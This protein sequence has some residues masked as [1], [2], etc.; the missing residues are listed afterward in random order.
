MADNAEAADEISDI[1]IKWI[2]RQVENTF[3]NVKIEKFQKFMTSEES[4][5]IIYQFLDTSDVRTLLFNES[6]GSV[7]VSISAPARLKGVYLYFLKLQPGAVSKQD[8]LNEIT[9]GDMSGEP[10]VHMAKTM[11]EVYLPLLSNPSNQEAWSE[12]VTKDVMERMQ[13][14][15]AALQ[16]TRGQCKGE[17]Y[18]PLPPEKDISSESK[19]GNPKDRVHVLEGCL[20]T[21]TKQIKNVLKQ[22]PEM[23]LNQDQ[24][25]PGPL[26]ELEFWGAKASNLNSIFNQLQGE[27]IRKVLRFLDQSKSTYNLPFAKL[28]KEVFHAR[29]EAND[30]YKFLRPLEDWFSRLETETFRQL[31]DIFRPM[32]HL[33]L[34][35][36]KGSS[37]YNTPARLVVLVREVCNSLIR[38]SCN[39]TGGKKIFE[40]ID[41]EETPKVVEMLRLTL[42]VCGTFKST[43]FDYKAKANAED[44]NNQWRVQNN[45]LFVRLD[46]FLDRCHDLLELTQTIVQFSMLAKIEIGGT[47]G[48]T[49]TTSVHQ[50]HADFVAAVETIQSVGYDVM[51]L[52]A[53]EFDDDFYEFRA[54]IKELERRLGSVVTQGFDDCSSVTGHFKLLDSFEGLLERPLVQDELEK[55]HSV[56]IEAYSR[57]L[58][59]VQQM[60]M[61]SRDDPPITSNLP[62]T[63]GAL[64]WCHGLKERVQQPM[65]KLKSLNRAVMER[66]EAKD[67]VKAY[68]QLVASLEEFKHAKIE[69]WG[70]SIESSSQ[71]QLKLPLLRREAETHTLHV[72]FDPALVR[73][74][75]EVKYFL[76]LG[77]E[78]PDPALEIHKKSEVFRRQ[79]GNLD[80]IVNMYNGIQTSLLPVERPLVKSH[81]DKIDQVLAKGLRSLN[82]KSHGIDLFITESMADVREAS[83][84]LATMKTNLHRVVE[85]MEGWSS[86]RLIERASKPVN[87]EDFN[88]QS[89]PLRLT[90]YAVI[91]EGGNEVHKLLKDTNKR[92]RVSNGL[93]DWKAYIDFVNNIIVG[94]LAKVVTVSLEYLNEQIDP[95]MI[96]KEDK[97]PLLEIEL[98]LIGGDV[99]YLPEVS[100]QGDGGGI[101]DVLYGWIETFFRVASIFKRL[102][103]GEGTYVKEMREHPQIQSL[104]AD[105]TGNLGVMNERCEEYR[106][107]FADYE[108][109][110]T[111]DLSAIFAEFLETAFLCEEGAEDDDEERAD[112]EA[113]KEEAAEDDGKAKEDPKLDLAK[114][115]ERIKHFLAVQGEIG[116]IKASC[117]LCFLRVNS[118]PIKQ[119]LS[120]W[121]TKWVYMYTQY[122][123]DHV[124]LKLTTLNAFMVTVNAGLD[125]EVAP[126]DKQALMKCM[127]HIRDVRRI[128]D[129]TP[130]EFEPLRQAVALLK[131]HGVSMEEAMIG[132]ENVVESLESAPMRWD[133]TVNH[134]FKKKEVIQPLQNQMVETIKR[135]ISNFEKKVGEFVANFKVKA[136]FKS[137]NDDIDPP[138]MLDKTYAV[139]DEQHRLL[140]LIESEASDFGELEEL[141]ELSTSKYHALKDAHIEIHQL[142][143]VWDSRALVSALF[144]D[145]QQALWAD[146]DTDELVDETRLLQG[147]VKALPR[148]V[149]GWQVYQ[150]LEANVKNMGVVLPLVHELHSPAMRDRHWRNVM[151]IARRHFEMGPQFCLEDVLG[152]GLHQHVDNVLEVVEVAN[153]ELKIESKLH[154]IE[155]SWTGLPLEFMQYKDT[156]IQIISSPDVIV[157]MLE[158]HQLQLQTMAGMGKFVDY[159]RDRVLLWQ[160]RLGTVETTLK[161]WLSVQKQWSSL[162]SIFLCSADIMAQLPDDSKR[163]EGIDTELKELMRESC[164]GSL[165]L[166]ACTR[167][168]RDAQLSNMH[169]E[170]QIC[171]KALNEYL[172][173]KK[174]IFPRF[175]FVSNVALLDILSNGNN[176]PKVMPHIG[177]CFDGVKYLELQEPEEEEHKDGED[178]HEGQNKPK[179]IANVATKMISKDGEV[180]PLLSLFTMLGAVEHWLTELVGFM[181]DTLRE[182]LEHS[183]DTAANWEVDKPREQWLF[184]YPAQIVLVA[185]QIFWTEE[186]EGALEE[187]E[188]GQEDAVKS[189]LDLCNGRLGSLILLVL[190][191]LSKNDRAKIITLITID[192]HS[193][194]LVQSLIDKKTETGQDFIWQSQ[195]RFY[196]ADASRD[197]NIHICD[198]KSSYAY[199][200]VGNCG[201]LVITPLTDRCYV[202]L[203]T[204]LRLMLGGAP[205]GPAGT[206]KTETTKD[207]ARGL[208]LQCYVF[209]C[210]DQMNY[211]TMGDIFKGLSQ[212]GAWGC[213]D[214]FNRIII[215]VLSV[216]A[217]QVKTVLDAIVKFAVPGNREEKYQKLPAGTPPTKV[218]SYDFFGDSISLVP[219]TGFFIT[220]NPGYAG[221][222]ELPENLKA[223]FRS[224]AMI[225]PDLKP[226]CE[227]MLMAEGFVKARSLAVKFV[228]LY[229]L[230][231]E[232]LS[233]QA[234]YDWGLRAVKSV[235][236][237]AG[238]L[239]RSEPQI[240]EE[241]ILMRAL[242]DFNTPKI[243]ACDTP[244]FLQLVNDL[245]P[246]LA[247][248]PKVNETLK[249]ICIEVCNEQGLQPEEIFITKCVQYQELLDVRHSVMLLGPAGSAKSTIWK[250]LAACHNN[251]SS[252]PVTVY[253]PVNPKS[254]TSDELYG[255]MTLSKDWIDGCLS[256][257]M[258]NMSKEWA[259]YTAAQT[260]KWVILDGDIDAVWIES[261]NTV[262]DDNKVLT[263]VSNERIPLTAAMRMIF[264]IASLKNATPATVSRAGI[265]YLNE[266]DVGWQ[267]YVESWIHSCW[268]NEKQR[269]NF[270]LLFEK[271]MQK[272]LKLVRKN[273]LNHVIPITD[274][275][276][277]MTVCHLLEG[278]LEGHTD[279]SVEKTEAFFIFAAVWAL[280]GALASDKNENSRKQ[281]NELWRAEF[282]SVKYPDAGTVWDY[283]YSVERGEILPWTDQVPEYVPLGETQFANIVVP[284]VDSV[285]LSFLTKLLV[286]RQNPVMFVGVAGSGKTTLAKDFL[287]NLD[288]DTISTTIN[289]NY[290]T[291][292]RTLQQQLEQRI[293]KRSG[294]IYGPP[295]N[296][297]M[298]VLIDDLN[299]PFVEEY[300]TQTPIALL[301]QHVDYGGWYD[302]SDLGLRREVQDL[303]YIGCMNQK[304]GSFT[305]DPRLQRHFATF[306]C[307]MPG[308]E[309]LKTIYGTILHQHLATFNNG[310]Q[311][312]A[313]VVVNSTIELHHGVCE[314][315][316]PSAVKFHY[317]FNMRE[318]GAVFQGVCQSKSEY[319]SKPAKF[320]RLWLHEC[321]RVFSDRLISDNEIGRFSDMLVDLSKKHFDEDPN[322]LHKSPLIF[323]SFATPTIDETPAYLPVADSGQL[324]ECLQVKLKEYND[325]NPIM[326]L[327]L[328]AQAME[329]VTRITRILENPR[330]NALLVGVG[331]SG[332]QSLCKLGSFICGFQLM[333]ISVTAAYG[334]PDLKEDL[335]ELYRKAGLKPALPLVFMLTDAQIVNER[336]LVY[337]NDL[338]SS[339][340]IP[341][342]FAKDEID[343]ILGSLRNEAKAAGIPDSHDPMHEFFIDR[344]RSNLHVVLCMSPV[345]DLFRVRARKFPGLINCTSIDWFHAWPRDALVSVSQR[346]LEDVDLGEDEVKENISHHMAEVH[347]SVGKTSQNY[348]EVQRRYN[349]TT[350]KTF[351]DLIVYYK[352]LLAQ[353]QAESKHSIHR[354]DSGLKTLQKTAKD[355][356]ALQGDLK[357]KLVTVA[358]KRAGTEALLEQMGTE[359]HEAEAQQAIADVE[360]KKAAGAAAD[361]DKIQ[362]QAEG[363]LAVAKPALDAANEAVNCLS[364]A[365][366]TELKSLSKP[367]AGV[368]KVTTAVLMMLKNE[369]KNYSW[370][371]AK[372]MMAKI[373]AFKTSLEKYRAETIPPEIVAKVDPIIADPNFTFEKMKVKSQAAANLCS[374]VVNTITFHKIYVR[375]KPLMDSL[376]A[377]QQV[378]DAAMA[379]LAVVEAQVAEIEDRLDALQAKFLDATTEK[380]RVEAEASAC[381]DRLKLAERLVSGLSSENERWG[382]EIDSLRSRASTLVGDVLLGAAFSSYVGAFDAG[383]RKDLWKELWIS[384]LLSREIPLTEG[385][386]P[387]QI[388]ST[389]ASI[390]DWL[391][392]GLPS[393]RISIENGAIITSCSRWPLLIDPQL[394]GI[395]WLRRREESKSSEGNGK[396]VILQLN[397]PGWIKKVEAAITDGS[398]VIIEALGESID[399]VLDP[400]LSRAVYRKGRTLFLKFGSEEVEYDANFRLYL[401]TKLVNPHYKPEV[402]AQCTL[403]NF[404]V[405]E[406]GLEE[407]LL[408]KVVNCEQHELE[409]QKQQLQQDFNNYQIQLLDLEDQLLERLAN[410]PDDI[411]SDV[412]LIEGVEA[413]K[414][415]ATEINSAVKK[416]KETEIVINEAREVYRLIAAE[417]S[418][419]YFLLVQLSNIN[420]MYQYS[421]DSF[422]GFFFKSIVKAEEKEAQEERVQALRESLRTTI[423]TWVSRGLFEE[424]KL[425]FMTQL[426]I[427]LLQRKIVGEESGFGPQY[428]QFLLRCP[429]ILGDENP[430]DWLPEQQWNSLQALIELEGFERFASDF[431]DNAP[432]FQEW[433]NHATPETE[434]LPLDWREL[435]RTPFLKLLVLSCLRPDRLTAALTSFIAETVPNGTRYTECDAELNSFQVLEQSFDDSGPFTPV[436]FVL[437]PGANIVA[438]LD[439]LAKKFEM[440]EGKDYHNISL[441]QGQDI[442]AME[443]LESGNQAGHWVVL[444]NVHLMPR[445]LFKLQQTL[446]QLE[447]A[448]GS[449]HEAFRVFLSSDPANSIPIGLLERCIKL[450]NEPPSGLKANLKRAFCSFGKEDF[451]DMEP[452]TKGILF[453]LCHFHAV[454]LERKKFGPKGFNMMYPFAVG[455]L[456]CSSIVLKNYMENAPTKVPWDDLRYLFGEIMYGGHVVNDFDRLVCTKYLEFFMRDQILD[457]MEMFPYCDDKNSTFAAPKTSNSYDRI[458]EHIDMEL[459]SDTPLAFGLHP[460]AE[461]GFRTD[462]AASVFKIILETQPRDGA[463]ADSGQ[464]ME[465]VAESTLQDILDL[466]QQV[467][468]DADEIAESMEEVGP[469]QNVFLQECER[470]NTLLAEMVRSLT[471]LELGFRGDLTMSDSMELLAQ[472]LYMNDIPSVWVKVAFPSLRPL[473]SWLVDLQSR[474][475]QITD[476]SS[477]PS[478]N[479]VT[480]WVSGLFNP[481]S[482]LTAIMQVTSQKNSLELDKLV[483]VTEPTKR[484]AETIDMPAREGSFIH[485]LSLEGARWDIPSGNLESSLPK[486]MFCPMPVINCKAGVADGAEQA[487]MFFCPVYKT[488]Q[489]GPTY[490]FTANLRTKAAT[491]KW[492]LGGVVLVMDVVL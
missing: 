163:F 374:W 107:R 13:N 95:E 291:D 266:T 253:E 241:L 147:Q 459:K 33:I 350:P 191:D 102:D 280:G 380:A 104:L 37:F 70:Q 290:Y 91:R 269:S 271:Y 228:T 391:K 68:T 246:G 491:A 242:R 218:G 252:K 392:D 149:R 62:P 425:I 394:Q 109:L 482:F 214:E 301:N 458:L 387:L 483:I 319:Y 272:A 247:L 134:T 415:K 90:R 64:G 485:G 82:W 171:Q 348:M 128:M 448:E 431:A 34:A 38:Q 18:L 276:M 20:I 101:H 389:D 197:T 231:S 19:F 429:K 437:S 412:P 299:M 453:G 307:H 433:Y 193:R 315:F 274:I 185:S 377:A 369:K 240:D 114:F 182:R 329:H 143:M 421:L 476:W 397:Q 273:K 250:T 188:N 403:I 177:D 386:D 89:K 184:D 111:S 92:L 173:V 249:K 330:G 122:L 167:E 98:D 31:T 335:K 337:V 484:L 141:F 49:L 106:Q 71:A 353:K 336:F 130:R 409:A 432:R 219:T 9:V 57:D 436:Y 321:H 45:A 338:L 61:D 5:G 439:K 85:L 180:V 302:R 305:V 155:D 382:I 260:G 146:I 22:D 17:V 365:S 262:M 471:E 118:Q 129:Q 223:Q 294:K 150:Q 7:S 393:D 286:D 133:N 244:I 281:F 96:L 178:E 53:K 16:I 368:D 254:V 154:T 385:V 123:Y 411:L 357:A 10:L 203:T 420:H 169:K 119:A 153:K 220:M 2:Y 213:F 198:F 401:Q 108:Y 120:T 465:S 168:G 78:V 60:F 100:T 216:V 354:L 14:M 73:L 215:E 310:V 407:Q 376:E 140:S 388:L 212:T 340:Y 26:S 284:T 41:S 39:Y 349:Y 313:A 77:L 66:E 46:A 48:K 288:E 424:H 278:L 217:T 126:G 457:E 80:L 283:Y 117:D 259:P 417:G 447:N 221:R 334:V 139:L 199:E 44:P 201:R 263:L 410:A 347:L 468:Y 55:K 207:L 268:D 405:T 233:K 293:D 99:M 200:Y 103:T 423:F 152:L 444:H 443:R 11:Q 202:T 323:T 435:D 304:S 76:L 211:Q 136:P 282:K 472:S 422:T 224:C 480:T 43:Y 328:F 239:K 112:E 342:L 52:D 190:D 440:V 306:A 32:M 243:P 455:D 406:R 257:V 157:E 358:E 454:I 237:V 36:W 298:V 320:L 398:A 235:L 492:V 456:L 162:E 430:V 333:Q 258:R 364:K 264:E 204:A 23:L 314:Q 270:V 115:D 326:D 267:P 132:D 51:D 311:K 400:V 414:N 151:T 84:L 63:A 138:E 187:L 343:S 56:L 470:M 74:L 172:E 15:L 251:G 277:V 351:L 371:N 481:Q 42:R 121:V 303:Q 58:Q 59:A 226:I 4:L 318:Y 135:D 324:K 367:P 265:L 176:P 381:E 344:V 332:K 69:A 113:A 379:D 67:L 131:T 292:S 297:K 72:N 225:R 144:S 227:N 446:E 159:F 325:A 3:K 65:Q 309:D 312:L 12:M 75:R 408:A 487:N 404:I 372:K 416:G 413:T 460:N 196:W 164:S 327:V 479:P 490:V 363:E 179:P 161:L 174:N 285:R 477:T 463:S 181:Q 467:F 316:L 486:E 346:F 35:V 341:D 79:T 194:D 192:V 40:M 116:D 418:M 183:L 124:T 308:V 160:Q 466:F 395:K 208:G 186:C 94:G 125:E 229:E 255:Y 352:S 28:C 450:T 366:L 87:I 222:T 464:S 361:A 322:E 145:W 195:L 50:I 232:L 434:K 339:G 384:D 427:G 166:D 287:R 442:V 83:A 488:Q 317:N 399:A 25:H 256:I 373:D 27:R 452:R 6:S 419:L 21:W 473:A 29:A 148:T 360:R 248:A 137:D 1:R 175:Y 355:V 345:G 86:E 238:K 375:V 275:S 261:M 110:W 441:G 438:D 88:E 236:R 170:L 469:F 295:N 245:F 81:L 449:T 156:D 362:G 24:A 206:G 359:R 461:I 209:N 428:L 97:M 390:A 230:S 165:V 105:V 142:K 210:S 378:K 445:W 402:A 289:M 127:T 93:P 54:R 47:K 383:F 370:D 300:G 158:E 475:A 462:A 30:N 474:Q 426:T 451:E 205:A 478:E 234:H 331:G 8:Y 356:E 189:Y 296:K 489:R 396:L 279:L